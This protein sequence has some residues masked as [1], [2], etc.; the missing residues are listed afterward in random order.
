MHAFAALG[1]VHLLVGGALLYLWLDVAAPDVPLVRARRRDHR[2]RECFRDWLSFGGVLLPDAVTL[3]GLGVFGI[4][5]GHE[6]LG[7]FPVFASLIYVC[8]TWF[9][10][11]LERRRL[12]AAWREQR[13]RTGRGTDL[14]RS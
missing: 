2:R 7:S 14:I 9:E 4:A 1:L 8:F 10:P 6:V 3:W 5:W 12:A 11:Q 13:R